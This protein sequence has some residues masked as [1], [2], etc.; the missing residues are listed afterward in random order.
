M[1]VTAEEVAVAAAMWVRAKRRSRKA[2]VI[3]HCRDRLEALAG[4]WMS[5]SNDFTQ[6][7]VGDAP[8]DCNGNSERTPQK[9]A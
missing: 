2:A 7:Q 1:P 5:E 8:T 3:K 4:H 9:A 6:S